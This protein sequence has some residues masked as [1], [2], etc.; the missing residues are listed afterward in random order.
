MQKLKVDEAA[1]GRSS[2]EDDF[3][4]DYKSSK[5]NTA[6]DFDTEEMDDEIQTATQEKRSKKGELFNYVPPPMAGMPM[7]MGHPQP[8]MHMMHP[9][10]MGGGQTTTTTTTS[11]TSY[12]Y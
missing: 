8:G 10:M 6:R 12:S 2:L 5:T 9:Q 11:T 3:D 4:S 1:K 7:P